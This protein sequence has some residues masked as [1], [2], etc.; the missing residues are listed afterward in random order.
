MATDYIFDPIET[1]WNALQQDAYDFLS[2]KWPG[3]VPNDSNLETWQIAALAR[4]VAEATDVA[5]DV[6]PSIFKYF[7]STILGLPPIGATSAVVGSTWTLGEN[8]DGR[9]IEEGTLV[10]IEGTD[11][12]MITFEVVGDVEVAAGVMSTVVGEVQLRSQ[13]T[14]SDANNIGG[15]GY[16][17]ELIDPLDWVD[18]VTLEGTTLGGA[19]EEDEFVYL[20]RLR[21]RMTL[22]SPRPVT[23]KDFEVFAVDVAAQNGVAARAL[24]IDGYDPVTD[25]FDNEKTVFVV[26]ADASTGADVPGPIRD[27]VEAEILDKREVNFITNVGNPT[28]V[29]V[30]VTFVGIAEPGFDP[31]D[32]EIRAVQAINDYL[33]PQNFGVS[34]SEGGGWVNREAIYR[35]DISTVLNT[36]IGFDRWTTLTIGLNGGAQ[37]ADEEFAIVGVAPLTA[38]GV[39]DGTVT[40]A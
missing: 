20:D 33:A 32:V 1:D 2:E 40:S 29:T 38:S 3:W 14:G 31:A 22:I 10:A 25:T 4:M 18:S 28:R 16:V 6:P 27:A 5:S 23:A 35:Q 37:T 17:A 24:A 11:G 15:V 30:D 13:E 12:A 21:R 9:T 34:T 8:P 7:G 36:V 26:L 39:I 19:D